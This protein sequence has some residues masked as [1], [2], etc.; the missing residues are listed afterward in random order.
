MMPSFVVPSFVVDASVAMTWLF[1]DEMTPTTTRLLRRLETDAV[2]VPAL[3]YLEITN[4]LAVAERKGRVSAEQSEDFIALL[5]GVQ[6]DV[7]LE[8]HRGAFT[9]LLAICRKFG[10]SS[11]DATYLELALRRK[12]PLASLDEPLR[13]AAK[14]LGVKLLGK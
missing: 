3:W 5:D 14:K 7:D 4:T 8:T 2:L 1:Q 10:L 6:I 11:Y 12:L 9:D 13:K